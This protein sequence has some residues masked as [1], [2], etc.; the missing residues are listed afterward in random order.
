MA[1]APKK[2]KIDESAREL[3]RRQKRLDFLLKQTEVFSKF[4]ASTGEKPDDESMID[5]N[6]NDL[7]KTT[8]QKPMYVSH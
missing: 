6:S 7:V 5:C 1:S 8:K 2:T 4:F 3:N